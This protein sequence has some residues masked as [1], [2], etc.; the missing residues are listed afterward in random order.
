MAGIWVDMRKNIFYENNLGYVLYNLIF[1]SSWGYRK[2]AYTPSKKIIYM[3]EA[4]SAFM[5]WWVYWHL[6]HEPEH[7]Y[8]SYVS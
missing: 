7:I 3:A 1:F 4:V 8:V 5:W 2:P 6:W